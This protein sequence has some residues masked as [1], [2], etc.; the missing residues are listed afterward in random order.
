MQL[1]ASDVGESPEPVALSLISINGSALQGGA[2]DIDEL[3]LPASWV[4]GQQ[5]GGRTNEVKKK[6][7]LPLRKV[8]VNAKVTLLLLLLCFLCTHLGNI[9]EIFQDFKGKTRRNIRLFSP[10]F[11]IK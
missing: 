6:G 3:P 10:P 2:G 4:T 5:G 1:A 8:L 7:E 11:T 9:I